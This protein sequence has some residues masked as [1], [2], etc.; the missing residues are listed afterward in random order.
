M[1]FFVESID[2]GLKDAI[3]NGPYIPKYEKYD[4][5]IENLGPS[6]MRLKE[7]RLNM[8]VLQRTS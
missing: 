6:K 1:K 7:K 8:I 5:F 3:T 2:R 4:F